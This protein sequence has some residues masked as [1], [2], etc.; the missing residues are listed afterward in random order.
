VKDEK[1][2]QRKGGRIRIQKEGSSGKEKSGKIKDLKGCRT[3]E[4]TNGFSAAGRSAGREA[5]E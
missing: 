5:E 2:R 1:C 4:S 3:G